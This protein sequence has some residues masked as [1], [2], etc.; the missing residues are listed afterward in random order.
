M[1][2]MFD[3]QGVTDPVST[4]FPLLLLAF[5]GYVIGAGVSL[6]RKVSPIFLK[7]FLY[8]NIIINFIF[9][10]S[11][12]I[13]G[14]VFHVANI[15]FTIFTGILIII[16][17]TGIYLII[18]K[19]IRTI[20]YKWKMLLTTAFWSEVSKNKQGMLVILG[21]SIFA[22]LVAYHG[23]IIYFHSVFG[24]EYDSMNL[25]LPISK[26]ILLGDGLNH[27]FYLGA[28]INL[29]YG[30]FTLAF[31]AWLIHSFSYSSV[32][33][34]PAYFVL[35]SAIATYYFARKLYPNKNLAILCACIFLITPSLL[36]TSSKYSL[37]Q[38][39]PFLFFLISAFYLL[40]EN[41]KNNKLEFYPVLML[42][43][44]TSVLPLSREIGLLVTFFMLFMLP[45]IGFTKNTPILRAVL[46]FLALVP[47]YGL[48]FY[49]VK[50]HGFTDVVIVR[51]LTVIIAHII[52]YA[53]TSGVDNHSP[54]TTLFRLKFVYCLIPLCIPIIFFISNII[55]IQ[56]LYAVFSFDPQV[57]AS[58]S[59]FRQFM[60]RPNPIDFGLE[61]SLQ[62]VPQIQLMFVSV[63]MGF[64]FL[65]F[66]IRGFVIMIEELRK[67]LQYVLILTLIIL[68]LITWSYLLLSNLEEEQSNRHLLYLI[69]LISLVTTIGM[70]IKSASSFH[71]LYCY[72]I[73]LFS[74]FY[75]LHYSM[76]TWNYQNN[77]IFAGFIIKDSVI[78]LEEIA[79][80]IIMIFPFLVIDYLKKRPG[81][82][83]KRL[84]LSDKYFS[85]TCVGIVVLLILTL[86]LVQVGLS[87]IHVA[88]TIAPNNWEGNA[89]EV[90]NF[91]NKQ[92]DHKNVFSIYV[93]PIPFFANRTTY[94]PYQV[95]TI[96]TFIL[97]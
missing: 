64:I 33:L 7:D 74:T 56:G 28:D 88:D 67:N 17:I 83:L 18:K 35:M 73:V 3:L 47:L 62:N 82:L 63:Q 81:G 80:S 32:K 25:F 78:G 5:S 11:F 12:V 2:F 52:I 96:S 55:A 71:Y 22:I 9:V 48:S 93:P 76:T 65:V 31:D 13:F 60:D 58:A 46:I 27:D 15:Y 59:F 36:F 26:S 68:M 97:Y 79:I 40:A 41:V 87:P 61:Q 85:F 70:Q 92:P 21:A 69:P 23:I 50:T 49:D 91:L 84:P 72:G 29:R 94:D 38:D 8:G 44:A 95:G 54:F 10:S 34:F 66:K 6:I 24:G 57:Q 53:I 77:T 19:K 4:I 86:S 30:P 14:I 20:N 75:F 89:N 37:Q 39:I 51:L 16:S 1:P 42:V 43:L 45:A 90:I